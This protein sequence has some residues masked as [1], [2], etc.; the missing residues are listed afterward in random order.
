[1]HVLPLETEQ[2][3]WQ[4]LRQESLAKWDHLEHFNSR[5][6]YP[7]SFTYF[8]N[9][10]WVSGRAGTGFGPECVFVLSHVWLFATPWTGAQQASP[11]LGFSGQEHWGGLPFPPPGGLPAPLSLQHWQAGSLPLVPPGKPFLCLHCSNTPEAVHLG[12]L[13]R[14]WIQVQPQGQIYTISPGF[15]RG[16]WELTRGRRNLDAE[17]TRESL[18]RRHEQPQVCLKMLVLME[19]VLVS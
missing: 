15:S 9:P 8:T 5:T 12:D 17:L 7:E 13:L 16:Q 4:P 14:I 11:S 10:D 1:M 18:S 19:G 6:V 2:D 3:S